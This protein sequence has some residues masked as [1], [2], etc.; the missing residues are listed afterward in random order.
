MKNP[1]KKLRIIWRIITDKY[2][3]TRKLIENNEVIDVKYIAFTKD[4]L[5]PIDDP[6][7]ATIFSFMAAWFVLTHFKKKGHE[8]FEYAIIPYYEVMWLHGCLTGKT[9]KHDPLK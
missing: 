8:C 1:F 4:G 7:R 5:R 9:F 3:V 6:Q 2:F